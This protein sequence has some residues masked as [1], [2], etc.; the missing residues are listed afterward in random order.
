MFCIDFLVKIRVHGNNWHLKCWRSFFLDCSFWSGCIPSSCKCGYEGAGFEALFCGWLE[1]GPTSYLSCVTYRS[2]MFSVVI[3]RTMKRRDGTMPNRPDMVFLEVFG[4]VNGHIF[5]SSA[6]DRDFLRG[7]VKSFRGH[8]K[9]IWG[10]SWQILGAL[11][12]LLSILAKKSLICR[13]WFLKSTFRKV[14]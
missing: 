13:L 12:W 9:Q 10:T 5:F 3:S 8:C 2:G 14:L 7:I 6:S 11:F 1:T 4:S